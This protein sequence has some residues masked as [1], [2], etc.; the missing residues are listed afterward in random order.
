MINNRNMKKCTAIIF[1]SALFL[2]FSCTG[3]DSKSDSTNL[4]PGNGQASAA[5]SIKDTINIHEEYS[6][7]YAHEDAPSLIVDI[8][9]PVVELKDAAAT[10]R[11]DS[12]L[13]LTL[14]DEYTTLKDACDIFVDSRKKDFDDMHDE[15]INS[16]GND[17]PAFFFSLY[18]IIAGTAQVGYKDCIT[19]IVTHEEY[20]GGAHPNTYINIINFDP[21]NGGEI[22]LDDI[23]KEGYEEPLTA[24]LTSTLMAK[25]NATTIDE[26]HNK[27]FL[28]FDTEMFVSNNFILGNDNI[29]FLYNRYEIAPYAAGEI[30]LTIDY[31]TLKEIMK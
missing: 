6:Y 24:I 11:I 25:A 23:F 5:M 15:Y 7:A 18:D 9:L 8:S 28:F 21:A 27:G 29:T 14:F 16:V 19:Y 13:A 17:T 12:T 26:L 10:A 31:N 20:N 2:L 3:K 30:L 1:Y 4:A 22:T